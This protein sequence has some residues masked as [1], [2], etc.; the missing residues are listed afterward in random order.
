MKPVLTVVNVRMSDEGQVPQ[1]SFQMSQQ[2]QQTEN[3]KTMMKSDFDM[4]WMF[5]SHGCLVQTTVS[6]SEV[7]RCGK[8]K[9]I[10]L[11]SE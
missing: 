7:T 4:N 10:L 1:L 9:Q 5:E 2:P 3:I 6:F 8:S 11:N